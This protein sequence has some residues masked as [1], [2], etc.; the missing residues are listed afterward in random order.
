MKNPTRIEL[1]TDLIL[2]LCPVL[3]TYTYTDGDEFNWIIVCVVFPISIFLYLL[4][5]WYKNDLGEKREYKKLMSQR[6]N[7]GPTMEDCESF[8][9]ANIKPTKEIL[10]MLEKRKVLLDMVAKSGSW[11]NTPASDSPINMRAECATV[12]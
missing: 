11:V 8:H 7:K 10:E 2:K 5:L 12:N 1:M 4:R 3:A 6:K 9:H